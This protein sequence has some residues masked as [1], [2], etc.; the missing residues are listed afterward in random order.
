MHTVCVVNI[1]ARVGIHTLYSSM[2]TTYGAPYEAM[3]IDKNICFIF[4]MYIYIHTN[5]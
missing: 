4:S 3:I 2:S 1:L 5:H